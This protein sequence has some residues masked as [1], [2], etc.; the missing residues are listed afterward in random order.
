MSSS[1]E[2]YK[3]NNSINNNSSNNNE[4][5]CP[6]SPKQPIQK[7]AKKPSFICL[8]QVDEDSG[9]GSSQREPSSTSKKLSKSNEEQ[10]IS[11]DVSNDRYE[12]SFDE[13]YGDECDTKPAS[14]DTKD[15][16]TEKKDMEKLDEL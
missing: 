13:E 10:N 12:D 8:M 9:S 11:S 7:V 2:D 3:N 15:I 6:K 5:K 16:K 1:D 14:G 4:L